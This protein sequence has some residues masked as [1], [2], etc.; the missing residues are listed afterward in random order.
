MEACL[1]VCLWPLPTGVFFD[2][3]GGFSGSGFGGGG[4]VLGNLSL[5]FLD[6][7]CSVATIS[8]AMSSISFFESNREGRC[9]IVATQVNYSMFFTG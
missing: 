3:G 5:P 7:C 2:G 1:A 8:L 4:V 6:F 9:K